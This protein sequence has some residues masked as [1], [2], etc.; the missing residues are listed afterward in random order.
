[1]RII[2]TITM[3]F[4]LFT[5]ITTAQAN[6]E[7]SKVRPFQ[8]GF[9][10][11]LGTNGIE[12][13]TIANMVSFNLLGG[14]SHGN[15]VFEASPLFNVNFYRTTGVQMVGILNYSGN[16]EN[17]IQLAGVLNTSLDGNVSAQL[18][19]VLNFAKESKVQLSGVLNTTA[20]TADIQL[21]GALNLAK[22]STVQLAGVSNIT[23]GTTGV[24]LGGGLNFAKESTVQ[25]AGV[26]N[27]AAGT[28]GTQIGVVNVAKE[29]NGL[30]LG[31]VNYA[32]DM[33]GIPIG[34]FSFVKNAKGKPE[35]EVGFSD[36]LNTFV[37]FKFGV[38]KF[39]TIFSGGINYIGDPVFM[40]HGFGFGTQI[41]LT[42]GWGGQIELMGYQIN[43]DKEYHWDSNGDNLSLLNQ[44]KVKASKQF[45]DHFKVS[46]GPVFN[47]T[48]RRG[49]RD[50]LS[51]WSMWETGTKT[52]IKSWIG[53]EVGASVI[54]N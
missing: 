22:E 8:I 10:T 35:F 39:Y 47:M 14:Y 28:V 12:S 36:S 49:D 34:L 46:A 1:M 26:T 19:G 20:G 29:V 6:P 45:G 4:C 37:S 51:S 50:D 33:N 23:I 2:I 9:V 48:I 13:H 43:K 52:K 16:T 5:V 11:P 41:D 21:G 42:D 24:Q 7:P 38:N 3:L 40:A 30:Q 18:G 15:Y 53:V 54:L 25:L 17:A 27:V 32:E 31:L 44:L